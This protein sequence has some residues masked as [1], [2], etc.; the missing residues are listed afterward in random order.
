M[1]PLA[2]MNARLS[3][4]VRDLEALVRLE[5]P[6]RD[7]EGLG[8]AA[9]FLKEAF[10]PLG[11]LEE[12]PL[13]T[14]PL[15]RFRR[16]GRGGRVLLLLHYDTVHPRGAFPFRLEG[17][18][19]IGPGVYDMKGS[20]VQLLYA[21]RFLE[22][23]GLSHPDLTALFTPDEEIGSPES[24][25]FIEEEARRADWVLVLEPPTPEGDLKVARKG[26]GLYRLR[27]LGR[28][29]HQ[30][31]EPEKGV[32]AILELAH[33]T[34]RVAALEDRG[35]GTTLGPNRVQG[36]T[37]T[38]VVAEEAVLEIDLRAWTLEEVQRVEAGLKALSPVL[39]GARL[40]LTG[41]LN[42]PP[43]EPTPASLALFEKARDL[44][45]R[46]GLDLKPGRVGGGSDGNF[47]T[48]F[49]PTLDGLGL[50]GRDAHQKREAV[51]LG[52]VPR[53]VALLALLLSEL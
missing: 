26:V 33:Q 17:D 49:A 4:F 52:E 15:L 13:S 18:L 48:P 12:R 16:A 27:A 36:G 8:R 6:S 32:N 42:R 21:L 14:G 11:L 20:F 31:V 38:N 50:F 19:A 25:P 41:G 51:H 44:G 3:E 47:T 23:A 10:S 29:A 37:A 28:A 40:E 7:L 5:S 22:E 43:M 45:R 53:R 1:D 24:R 9:G 2:W 46:L 34:L 39:E 30:G 35:R